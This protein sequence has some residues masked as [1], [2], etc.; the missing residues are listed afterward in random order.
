MKHEVRMSE[1]MLELDAS[2]KELR[3]LYGKQKSAVVITDWAQQ[4]KEGLRLKMLHLQNCIQEDSRRQVIEKD[5]EGPY[6]E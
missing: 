6:R 4:R 1:E 2:Q 5:R 3:G